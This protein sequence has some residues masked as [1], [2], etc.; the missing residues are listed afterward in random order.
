MKPIVLAPGIETLGEREIIDYLVKMSKGDK[1]ILVV[2]SRT[3]DWVAKGTIPG[4]INITIDELRDKLDQL[5]PTKRTVFYCA[6]GYRSYLAARIAGS[7][8]F[9]QVASL[10]GGVLTWGLSGGQ[11]EAGGADR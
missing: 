8:G 9:E 2:D 10:S 3:P 7:S 1:S 6:S 4:A 11:C 5:D